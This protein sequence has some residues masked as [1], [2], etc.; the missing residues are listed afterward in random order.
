MNKKKLQ[1]ILNV[2]SPDGTAIDM[3]QFD[4][5]VAK[6]KEGL[7]RKIQV[8][9]L[10]DVN[11]QFNTLKKSLDLTPLFTAIDNIEKVIGDRIENV[12]LILKEET[13]DFSKLLKD[14]NGVLDEKMF[15]LSSSIQELKSELRVLN[16]QKDGEVKGLRSQLD[17]M[18]GLGGQI[19]SL[20]NRLQTALDENSRGDAESKIAAT[21]ELTDEIEKLRKELTNRINNIP[22]GGGANRNIAIGGNT[23]VLSTF[24]D[25]N[26]KPGANV[27]ITYTKNQTTKYTDVTIAAT[28]GGGGTTRSI[29]TISTSQTA[30]ATSGTDYVYIASAGIQLTLPDAT[31]N[32]N[33]YT[34]KNTS[35]SSVL[36]STTSAQTIDNDT[37]II[38]PVRYTSVD[39]ISD[40]ANWN[41]T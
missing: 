35:T 24:T 8:Q 13:T 15:G 23:S 6:L 32:T 37:T 25:I 17:G 18:S 40:G 21:K 3:S 27:T 1:N 19:T 33:L 2:L 11:N 41:V 16:N 7:K 36:V 39:L 26:F 28:G 5:E 14:N 12:N 4:T 30:G 10:E 31:G 34:V 29:N 22:R 38:M 20:G 9:T